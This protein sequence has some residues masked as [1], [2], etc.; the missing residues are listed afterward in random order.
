MNLS[1]LVQKFSTEIQATEFLEKTLWP[2]GP[3]CPHCGLVN[4]AYRLAPNRGTKTH[5]RP[6]VWKCRG[7][8]KQFTVKVGT[9]FEGSHIPLHKWLLVIHLLCSSKKGMSSH[10]IH[11]QIGITY[12][13]AWF[14]THRIR[15]AMKQEGFHALLKGTVEVDETYVGGKLRTGPLA[16]KPGERPKDRLAVTANKAP[17]VSLV[18]RGGK[19][20]SMAIA[21]VTAANL[22]Q[23]LADNVE[24]TAHVMTD[25][26]LAYQFV[27][28]AYARHSAVN[29]S[30]KEYSRLE[31]DGTRV[32]TNMVESFFSL[33][34]RGVYG[35]FH[36]ISLQ[37]LHRYLSEFDFRYNARGIDDGERRQLALKGVVGKRLTYYPSKTEGETDSVLD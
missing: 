1:E 31:A 35:S 26:A 6:G 37:H 5:V 13:S 23:V 25:E 32:S 20:R 24:Q 18:E 17:V 10:Q 34:K 4:E 29:H 30:E 7:C 2:D 16:T 27:A 14:M 15:Y 11:R 9:I 33:L 19:V 22:K 28:T 21:N 8:H 12:K 3:V 36:H